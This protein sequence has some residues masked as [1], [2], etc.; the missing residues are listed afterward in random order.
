MPQPDPDPLEAT[1]DRAPD[2][3]SARTARA[4]DAAVAAGRELGLTVTEPRVLYELFSVVVHLAPAPVAVRVP[5]VLTPTPN[6][7]EQRAAAQHDE[8]AV[9][10][11]LADQGFPVVPPSRLVPVEPVRR[12]GFSMTFWEYVE[13]SPEEGYEYLSDTSP[14]AELHA[15]LRRYPGRLP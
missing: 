3:V 2:E 15:E 1:R 14:V 11:W 13:T 8:L 4:R 7:L 5:T 10:S 9:T 6:A 12:D